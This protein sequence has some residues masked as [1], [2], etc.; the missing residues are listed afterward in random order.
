MAVTILVTGISGFAGSYIAEE[1][2][3]YEDCSIVGLDRYSYAGPMK[4]LA[5]LDQSRI[6][7]VYHD[8]THPLDAILPSL[9]NVD[10]ILHNGAETHVKNSLTD[11]APFIASNIMGTFNMLEAAR[12]LKPKKFLYVSTDEV[13]GASTIP[14]KEDDALTPSNPY[15]ATKAAGEYLVRAYGRTYGVPYIITRTTNLFGK[16]QHPEKFVPMVL[17]HLRNHS[18]VDIHTDANGEMG[19]RQWIHASDQASA[20][21]FLLKSDF[22]NE[23]FH[24][25]GERKTNLEI[26]DILARATGETLFWNQINARQLFS[27]HDLHYALDDSKLQETGWSPLLTFIHGIIETV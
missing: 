15:S 24:I 1:I 12:I 7:L 26:A 9:G 27:G 19:S 14:H 18:I 17:N 20:L 21:V 5:H 8:F 25:A 23:T 10:Y 3:K 2:L 11:P 22:V 16:R 4:N 6:K 13:F